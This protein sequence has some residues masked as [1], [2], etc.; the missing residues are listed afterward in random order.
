MTVWAAFFDLSRAA[1]VDYSGL[2]RLLTEISLKL[3]VA[4]PLL[5]LGN[6]VQSWIGF[7]KVPVYWDLD[8]IHPHGLMPVLRNVWS[9]ERAM[10][11]AVNFVFLVMGAAGT[12]RWGMRKLEGIDP[13]LHGGWMIVLAGSLSQALVEYGENPRYGVPFESLIV[14]TV[15]LG[16]WLLVGR[17]A[18]PAARVA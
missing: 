13:V 6:V 18:H 4:H 2:S 14:W 5:Y 8:L 11:L 10:L 1:D 16:A 15:I 17:R 7:W 3:I 9:V 12:V